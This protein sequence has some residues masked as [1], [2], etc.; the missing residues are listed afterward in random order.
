MI[1]RVR[2]GLSLA[3]ALAAGPAKAFDPFEIQ[4]YDGSIDDR[5]QAGLE[6]HVNRP[7]GG[8]LHVTLEPSFGLTDFW[9]LGGYFQTADGSYE[10]VKLRTKLAVPLGAFRAGVN[11]ELSRIPNEGWGGEI[12]PILAFENERFLLAVNPIVSFPAAFEPAAM[13]KLKLGVVGVGLE[14]YATLT[15]PREQYLFEAVDLFGIKGVEVNAA[16]GQ[17]FGAAGGQ[18]IFKTILGYAF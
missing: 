12:R 16:V 6:V 18:L 8:P 17:G 9:E 10:G 3:L 5:H 14:Y 13:A 11:F 15:E 1:A 4:V 7:R 2:F